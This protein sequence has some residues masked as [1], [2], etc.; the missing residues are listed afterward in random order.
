[1]FQTISDCRKAF[2]D[3]PTL[4]HTNPQ[5]PPQ[6]LLMNTPR[7]LPRLR[8]HRRR[9][10]LVDPSTEHAA[11]LDSLIMFHDEAIEVAFDRGVRGD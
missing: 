6:D 9:T 3:I 5:L 1:M 8:R 11:L 2:V 10:E 7:I 4:N